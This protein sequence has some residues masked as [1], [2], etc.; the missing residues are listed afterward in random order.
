MFSAV[1]A[2]IF[3]LYLSHTFVAII[4]SLMLIQYH[5]FNTLK[6][7]DYPKTEGLS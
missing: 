6:L 3:F 7:K 2:Y 1:I 4:E 5:C